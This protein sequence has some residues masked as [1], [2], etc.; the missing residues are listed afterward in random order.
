MTGHQWW[1][2][3]EYPHP[4]GE[5]S[6]ITANELHIPVGEVVNINLDSK[7]V[8]H[9][10]WIPKLAGKVD[11][12][13]GNNNFMWIQADEAGEYLGQC[14][15]FCG[16]AHAPDEVQGGC[17]AA[18]RLRYM[19]GGGGL[20]RRDPVDPLA[21]QGKALFEGS[22]AQ[23][24]SCH[25]VTGSSKSRGQTGPNLT[26]VWS[27]SHV[28][29]GVIETTQENLRQWL[30]DPQSIK[31]GTIM[32]RDAKIYNDPENKLTDADVAALVAYLQTLD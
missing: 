23:C 7:D 11:L 26:H 31:Q 12:V 28:A 24:W 29:A 19:A 5:S 17:G 22:K 1:F 3:F 18:R 25:T 9:S 20:G 15:E 13:P 2:E 30:E 10:F 8:L 4:D 21:Q 32:Y 6:V 27:R 16:E 14:A